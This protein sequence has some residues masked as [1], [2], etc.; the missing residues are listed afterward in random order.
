MLAI[1]IGRLRQLGRCCPFRISWWAIGFPLA[2][3][4]VAATQFAEAEP[5]WTT[6]ILALTL[7][8][9][10]TVVIVAMLLRTLL[11]VGRGEL[12]RLSG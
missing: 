2:A 11:D 8:S 3:A 6:D 12:R 10:A 7:L 4:S 9:L 1:L 5:G